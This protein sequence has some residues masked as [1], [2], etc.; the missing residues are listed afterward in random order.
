MLMRKINLVIFIFFLVTMCSCDF[1]TCYAQEKIIAIVNDDVI[2]QRDVDDFSK[3]MRMQ[4]S[5]QY[6]GRQL[7]DKINAMKNEL[8]DRL[9][10]DRIILQ[11]AKKSGIIIDEARVKAKINEIRGHYPSDIE[12]QRSLEMQGMTQSDL[13]SRIREQMLMY[14][15]VEIKVR[16]KIV[17]SPTEVTEFYQ[18]NPQEFKSAQV[19]QFDTL[20]TD[21]PEKAN[22][23]ARAIRSGQDISAVAVENSLTVEKMDVVEGQLKKELE[24][25]ILKLK[26]GEV[27]DPI[28]NGN[29][30]YIFK[31]TGLAQPKEQALAE[32]QDRIYSFLFNKKM[33]LQLT[34]WIDELKK[35]SYIKITQS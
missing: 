11:E 13:E 10:E 4:L 24:D 6:K 16:N 9:V 26:T 19:W 27:S 34:K 8:L 29:S 31:L 15:I 1:V 12:F 25:V 32:A 17:I 30:Y 28:I 3:Y 14:I 2:T 23:I 7:D 22:I 33:Q 18:K 21:S 35:Q 5:S 20:V